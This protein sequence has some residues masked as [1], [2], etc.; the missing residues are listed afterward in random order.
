MKF[1]DILI[2]AVIVAVITAIL[3]M[4]GIQLGFIPTVLLYMGVYFGTSF[5]RGRIS[6]KRGRK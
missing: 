3:S 1:T 2:G 6:D 4:N 5:V